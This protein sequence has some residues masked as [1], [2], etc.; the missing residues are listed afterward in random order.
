MAASVR[1]RFGDPRLFLAFE[2]EL[3]VGLERDAGGTDGVDGGQQGDDRRLVVG[4]AAG[5]QPPLG[6]ECGAGWRSGDHS[7]AVFHPLVT[8]RRLERR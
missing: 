7:T 1:S 5:V 4:G 6:I 2:C 8:Q 3:D